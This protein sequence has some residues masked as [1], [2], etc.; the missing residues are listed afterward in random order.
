MGFLHESTLHQH[1]GWWRIRRPLP[2]MGF[3]GCIL[4]HACQPFF[5]DPL[6]RFRMSVF[7]AQYTRQGHGYHRHSCVSFEAREYASGAP[8]VH[9][10][11]AEA[12]TRDGR[13]AK[14]REERRQDQRSIV[15]RGAFAAVR[16]RSGSGPLGAAGGTKTCR[17]A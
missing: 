7:R 2:R 8:D 13:D 4:D 6:D 16:T 12:I 10:Q 9:M 3:G 5:P 15:V 11:A 17:M 1:H 14:A